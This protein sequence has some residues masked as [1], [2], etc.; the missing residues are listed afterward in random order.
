MGNEILFSVPENLLFFTTWNPIEL[1]FI[2]NRWI[3]WQ[4]IRSLLVR[5]SFATVCLFPSI[6]GAAC[7]FLFYQ[8]G[9]CNQ[10]WWSRT[11]A[12]RPL[13]TWNEFKTSYLISLKSPA[14]SWMDCT[15][16]QQHTTTR[17]V[18]PGMQSFHWNGKFIMSAKCIAFIKISVSLHNWTDFFKIK[19]L[20]VY[21]SNF[22]LTRER[23][24][25]RKRTQNWKK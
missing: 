16:G 5:R 2:T 10:S 15:R 24:R 14:A 19:E 22:S 13:E 4:I 1:N 8:P 18:V 21:S 17:K 9:V 11:C 7:N 23:K 25:N 6:G 12:R 20:W 3:K